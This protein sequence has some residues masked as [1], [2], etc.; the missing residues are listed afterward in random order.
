VTHDLRQFRL[1]RFLIFI[2]VEFPRHLAEP[3]DL[4][5][6]VGGGVFGL[7][8]DFLLLFG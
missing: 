3:L 5:L 6:F 8:W 4:G 7:A 1:E 2:A